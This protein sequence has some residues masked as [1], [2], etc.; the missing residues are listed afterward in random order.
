MI[1]V[2]T[3][4]GQLVQPSNITPSGRYCYGEDLKQLAACKLECSG[5]PSWLCPVTTPLQWLTWAKALESHPDQ[6][7]AAYIVE[8]LRHGFRLGFNYTGHTCTSAK[9]NMLSAFQYPK[10][11]DKNQP[12]WGHP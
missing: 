8:G 2:P 3:G 10:V 6:D 5:V 7:F 11:I 4:L 12:V 1:F 9:H